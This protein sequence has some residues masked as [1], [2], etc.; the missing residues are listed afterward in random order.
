[1]R[2]SLSVHFL[3]PSDPHVDLSAPSLALCHTLKYIVQLLITFYFQ[4]GC[5]APANTIKGFHEDKTSGQFKII[6]SMCCNQLVM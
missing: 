2:S 3:L 4:A 5:I 6:F 1:M